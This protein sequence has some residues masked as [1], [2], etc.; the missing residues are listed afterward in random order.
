MKNLLP[1]ILLFT[2][3][4]SLAQEG[5]DKREVI[6]NRLLRWADFRGHAQLDS[7]SAKIWTDIDWS[8][9]DTFKKAQLP[10]L[11]A[12]AYF[13]PELSTVSKKFLVDK[14]DSVKKRV[15][16]HEQGHYNITRIAAAELSTIFATFPFHPDR[17]R[18]QADSLRMVMIKRIY[19]YQKLYDKQSNHSRN[20]AMQATWDK[21]IAQGLINK[22]LPDTTDTLT[23]ETAKK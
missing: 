6:E 17:Y 14:P 2:Y 12:A 7:Y 1:F 3:C 21:L 5:H 16:N 4:I 8:P 13:L 9:K 10:K 15:L 18:F 11:T 23:K 20:H 22:L 19:A